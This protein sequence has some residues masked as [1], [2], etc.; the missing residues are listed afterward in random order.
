MDQDGNPFKENGT[1]YQE[2]NELVELIKQGKLT[3]NSSPICDKSPDK[4]RNDDQKE[5]NGLSS[6]KKK[7]KKKGKN[8][9]EEI[10]VNKSIIESK[11][12]LYPEH[13]ELALPED[14]KKKK[15]SLCCLIQ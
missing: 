12:P 11:N 13:V 6:N 10:E 15:E 7:D 5:S 1:L 3:P 4:K 9:V 8:D 2:A 14:D